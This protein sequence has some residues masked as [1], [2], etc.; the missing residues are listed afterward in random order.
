MKRVRNFEV[1][2][3]KF[4]VVRTYAYVIN[5][6]PKKLMMMMMITTTPCSMFTIVT[7][8]SSHPSKIQTH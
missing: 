3:Y 1:I 4:N 5:S 8:N 6:S 2:P 7:I